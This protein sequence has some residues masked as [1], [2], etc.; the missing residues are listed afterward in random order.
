MDSK[1]EVIAASLLAVAVAAILGT[2]SYGLFAEAPPNVRIDV[3]SRKNGALSASFLPSDEVFLEAMLTSKNASI[4][5]ALVFFDVKT[6]NGTDFQPA[7]RTVP[8]D[9]LG[10]ANVTFQ[11]PWPSDISLGVWQATVTSSVYG[12]AI[13]ATTN[14]ECELVPPV[15]DVYTQKG[16]QGQNTPGGTFL[17]NETLILYAEVRDP[18]NHTVPHVLVAFEAK[19]NNSTSNP[20]MIPLVNMTDASGIA[21]VATRLPPDAAYAGTWEVYATAQYQDTVLIDTLTFV[22]QQTP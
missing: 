19:I 3:F 9:N 15:I 6:P 10:T 7:R 1:K 16:G 14:F 18:I 21:S 17:L 2:L 8:T 12:Q 4:A 11:I 22:A 13:N 5:G 20:W